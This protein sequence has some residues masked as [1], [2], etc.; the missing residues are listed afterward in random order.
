MKLQ[1]GLSSDFNSS[2][3]YLQKDFPRFFDHTKTL[4]DAFLLGDIG[5]LNDDTPKNSGGKNKGNGTDS[6]RKTINNN[7]SNNRHYDDNGNRDDRTKQ[8]IYLWDPHQAQG[9]RQKL[10]V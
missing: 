10:E 4:I 1:D 5:Y 3:H 8:P 2:H 6:N 7:K 9:V